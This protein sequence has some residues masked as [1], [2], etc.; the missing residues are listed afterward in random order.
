MALL[1]RVNRGD[2]G[3]QKGSGGF[4]LDKLYGKLSENSPKKQRKHLLKTSLKLLPKKR[5]FQV[6]QSVR[7]AS[8]GEPIGVKASKK[9]GGNS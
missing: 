5:V 2:E 3:D 6:N 9:L 4:L 1:R 7:R 8:K